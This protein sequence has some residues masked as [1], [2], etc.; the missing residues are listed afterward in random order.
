M[1]NGRL[2]QSSRLAG[3]QNAAPPWSRCTLFLVA[4]HWRNIRNLCENGSEAGSRAALGTLLD[5]IAHLPCRD[6]GGKGDGDDGIDGGVLSLG[7]LGGLLHEI[8][9]NGDLDDH[10]C[11]V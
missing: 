7:H 5:G 2:H 3:Q 1:E 9:G 8:I 10:G 4:R 6:L 11:A